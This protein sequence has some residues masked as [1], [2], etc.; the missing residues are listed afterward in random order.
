MERDPP[1][2]C[3][4]HFSHGERGQ[5]RR[6]ER[7]KTPRIHLGHTIPSVELVVEI[8]THLKRESPISYGRIYQ[9]ENVFL[10]KHSNWL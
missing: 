5:V 3:N 4:V 9:T 6:V 10:D 2:T 7:I 1:L 8:Q